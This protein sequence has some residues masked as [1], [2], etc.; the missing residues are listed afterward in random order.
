MP[1]MYTFQRVHQSWIHILL[2]GK[3][4]PQ[5][6]RDQHPYYLVE[7]VQLLETQ[8][9]LM[10]YQQ[11]NYNLIISRISRSICIRCRTD[12]L[13][14]HWIRVARCHLTSDRFCI[15]QEQPGVTGKTWSRLKQRSITYPLKQLG[16]Y[17]PALVRRSSRK[18]WKN[19]EILI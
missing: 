18:Q 5:T 19:S 12:Q 8:Q 4:M 7:G 15:E 11:V 13:K 10:H 14:V 9:P 17:S 2:R 1:A 3:L 16:N 6:P